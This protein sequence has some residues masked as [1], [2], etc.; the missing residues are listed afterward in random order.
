MY[1]C[2]FALPLG[3]KLPPTYYG[4]GRRATQ[5]CTTPCCASPSCCV[6]CAVLWPV[7]QIYGEG[8]RDAYDSFQVHGLAGVI[9]TVLRVG[10]FPKAGH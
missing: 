5:R 8:F 9:N 2:T 3:R 7:M 6:R 10:T 4:S 1:D